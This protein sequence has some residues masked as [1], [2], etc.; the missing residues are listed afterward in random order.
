[1]IISLCVRWFKSLKENFIF[2]NKSLIVTTY[3]LVYTTWI[4]EKFTLNQKKVSDCRYEDRTL[5]FRQQLL[6]EKKRED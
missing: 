6:K 2:S 1:M 4:N 5:N 3:N